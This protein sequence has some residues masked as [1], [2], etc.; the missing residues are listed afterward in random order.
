MTVENKLSEYVNFLIKKYGV[1][2]QNY[3]NMLDADMY[4]TAQYWNGVKEATLAT[5]NDLKDILGHTKEV[6]K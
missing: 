5:I 3:L 2:Y 6:L 4:T 1:Y